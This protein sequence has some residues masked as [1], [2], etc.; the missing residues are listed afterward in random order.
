MVKSL[1]PGQDLT[2]VT[3]PAFFLESR[4]L[5]ERLADTL[6]HPDALLAASKAA[7][8]FERMKGV[9]Q[10]FLSG[11]H[12]KTV[13][14]KK[15][16][17]PIIGETFA[18]YW[19]HAD[20][21]RSQYFA[22]QVLHR[23]PVSAIYFENRQNNIVATAHVWTKSQFSAPQTVKS[24]LEGACYL[25]FLDHGEMYYIT[26][27]TYY[28]HNLLIG[29]LRM[30]IGDATHV[31]CEKTGLRADVTFNQLGTFSSADRLHSVEGVIKTIPE[32]A[33]TASKKGGWFSKGG[34]PAGEEL[35]TITGHFD[36]SLFFTA[37]GGAT[38]L[39]M[40]L[41]TAPVAP[42]YV[43]PL[44]LQGPWESRR[45]WQ[46]A[47]SELVKRPIVDWAAV[48][49]EKAQLEEEQRM[50]PCHAAKPGAAGYADWAT[51][52][53]HTK[54]MPDLHAGGEKPLFVFDDMSTEKFKAGEPEKNL[55]HLSR[56]LGDPRGGLH[57]AGADADHV[58][59]MKTITLSPRRM[60]D[61]EKF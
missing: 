26:F 1:M 21:S 51:K 46:F 59:K 29:T 36:K 45:L 23:P 34:A 7:T 25:H 44:H 57:G 41:T 27:P 54:P 50:I 49:R 43:L 28:A 32:G 55:L 20:G 10:W 53:F 40:D 31:I 6:M 60:A 56:T 48:D 18:C 12:Y 4:S 39:L 42:K 3:I 2:R 24:I 22:E 15:P 8:P 11:F 58:T 52:K 30:D 33:G 19:K 14:V 17:N 5:L 61:W 35:G 38:T 9:V 13:G 16:Y 37:P 47:T